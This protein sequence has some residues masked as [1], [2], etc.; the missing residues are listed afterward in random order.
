M[1]ERIFKKYGTSMVLRGGGGDKTVRGIWQHTGSLGWQN[2]QSVYSPLGE[3]PRGQYL[4]ML[5]LEPPL[6]K[7]DTLYKDGIW[8]VVRRVEKIW[9]AEQAIYRWCLCEEGGQTGEW[10]SQS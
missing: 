4:L 7:G 8:Y 6:Q 9:H 1:I 2:M 3:I 10:T 5:P